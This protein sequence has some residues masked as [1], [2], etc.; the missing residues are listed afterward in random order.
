MFLSFL[1]HQS[2]MRNILICEKHNKFMLVTL[3]D[4]MYLTQ[5]KK[6]L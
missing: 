1:I 3:C 4:N 5:N 2:I 6:D